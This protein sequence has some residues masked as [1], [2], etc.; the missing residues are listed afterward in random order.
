MYLKQSKSHNKIYLSFVQGYRDENGKI[1]HKTIEKIGYLEVLKLKYDDPIEHFKKIAKKRNSEEINE[2]IIKNINTTQLSKNEITKNLGVIFIKKI[3]DELEIESFFRRK[4]KK[5]KVDYDLNS[6]FSLLVNSRILYPASKKETYKNKNIYFDKYNFSEDDM[7][8][9]LSYFKEYKEE[10]ELLLWRNTKEKYKRD[11][12]KTFYDCTNYYFE[13]EYNDN[14][15]YDKNNK[16]VK[17]GYRKRGPEKNHRPDPIIE[18]GLLMDSSGI[19]ISYN[20]FS[21]NK[22]EKLSLVPEINRLKTKFE[23]ERTIVV[24]DRGLN[25][26]DNIIKIAGT[27]LE[28]SLKMNGYVY[29]QSVR[30]A[31]SEFKEWVLKQ[32]YKIDIIDDNDEKIKFVHKS[33]IYPKTMY[34]IREDKGKTKSGNEIREK[35]TVDQKQLVYFSQKY[36]DKQKYDRNMMLEKAKDLIKNPFKYNK[37]TSYGAANYIK[38]LQFVKSTGEIANITNLLIDEDKIKEEQ[39]FDGYYSIV[40]SEES[41]N[42]IEIRNIYRG[43]AKIENTFKVTKSNLET[44]PVYVWTFEHIEAHFLICFIALVITRLLEERLENKYSTDKLI[45]SLKSFSSSHIEHDIYM[46]NNFNDIIEDLCNN[47]CLKLDKKYMTISNIKKI[48]N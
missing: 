14:D 5:L 8:R 47:F 37:A 48:F 22:S 30:S 26:S 29:G 20:L 25:C 17:E 36:A 7:Y 28:M 15:K 21:G 35:I 13:I 32:D 6:I 23:F 31:D 24:A 3:Y 44:R 16:L 45:Q 39:L 41:L 27:S 18:M 12:S 9:A 2:L 40:T 11:T 46:Q 43:L 19:P 33:R 10:L 38:N 4:N 34:V 42:D 1:K